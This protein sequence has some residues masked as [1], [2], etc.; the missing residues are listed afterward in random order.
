MAVAAFEFAD[1]VGRIIRRLGV[2]N[3]VAHGGRQQLQP[4]VVKARN[5]NVGHNARH[6][7]ERLRR[8]ITVAAAIGRIDGAGVEIPA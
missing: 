4:V 1:I 7:G 6:V 3:H 8:F 5:R 2:L